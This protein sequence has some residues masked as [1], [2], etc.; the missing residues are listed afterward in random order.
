MKNL[1]TIGKISTAILAL[2]HVII[3]IFLERISKLLGEE[4][5]LIGIAG[6]IAV[7]WL[8][9]AIVNRKNPFRLLFKAGKTICLFPW[10][11]IKNLC[12]M[13]CS[14]FVFQKYI[15]NCGI[16]QQRV[17]DIEKNITTKLPENVEIEN[18]KNISSIENNLD[19][20]NERL[21][22]VEHLLE[23]FLNYNIT[24]SWI[25]TLRESKERSLEMI[26]SIERLVKNFDVDN[27]DFGDLDD[28]EIALVLKELSEGYL[29]N[30]EE[31]EIQE[32]VFRIRQLCYKLKP[33][34]FPKTKRIILK[35]ASNMVATGTGA[36]TDQAIRACAE[37]MA[38]VD[39]WPYSSFAEK[40]CKQLSR[41]RATREFLSHVSSNKILISKDFASTGLENKD[42]V[43]A[44]VWKRVWVEDN[45]EWGSIKCIFADGRVCTKRD[46]MLQEISL[47][48]ANCKTCKEEFD[49]KLEKVEIALPGSSKPKIISAKA[50]FK[51]HKYFEK[52]SR[53]R[54][55]FAIE[56]IDI[57]RK[58]FA[59]L[60][61]FIRTKPELVDPNSPPKTAPWISKN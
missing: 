60:S 1:L 39:Q 16:L 9:Y 51:E 6:A 43:Y 12:S 26:T 5:A 61:D 46:K 34:L 14:L 37:I 36:I 13:F 59:T 18:K 28:N 35:S 56:F 2:I 55:G 30:S 15:K 44:R 45:N 8:L 54:P 4:K 58:D 47:F 38:N 52:N 41:I 50:R 31:K 24:F 27:P 11:A 25:T 53:V 49:A 48:G 22:R 29:S 42:P 19:K 32:G 20:V 21:T 40:L 3:C 10:I 17:E 23:D 57:D 7:L 33:D